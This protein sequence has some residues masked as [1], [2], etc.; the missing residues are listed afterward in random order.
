MQDLRS[1]ENEYSNDYDDSDDFHESVARTIYS[2]IVHQEEA[3]AIDLIDQLDEVD[4]LVSE[5]K[6]LLHC[7]AEEGCKNVVLALLKAG[8]DQLIPSEGDEILAD[9]LPL[10]YAA[11]NGQTKCVKALLNAL[12]GHSAAEAM[13][14]KDYAEFTPLQEAI[15]AFAEHHYYFKPLTKETEQPLQK[16]LRRKG[17]QN[18]GDLQNYLDIIDL[19]IESINIEEYAWDITPDEHSESLPY[20]CNLAHLAARFD[21]LNLFEYLFDTCPTIFYKREKLIKMGRREEDEVPDPASTPIGPTAIHTLL[22]AEY[23]KYNFCQQ[24]LLK[25][26]HEV[27]INCVDHRNRSVL[28]YLAISNNIK[29]MERVLEQAPDLLIQDVNGLTALDYAISFESVEALAVMLQSTKDKFISNFYC[30]MG[31]LLHIAYSCCQRSQNSIKSLRIMKQL[32]HFS[33]VQI[34]A[35]DRYGRTVFM[36]ATKDRNFAVLKLIQQHLHHD[37]NILV[38]GTGDAKQMLDLE[39]SGR[40]MLDMLEYTG[41]FVLDAENAA[42]IETVAE[43]AFDNQREEGIIYADDEDEGDAPIHQA[44]KQHKEGR[45]RLLSTILEDERVDDRLKNASGTKAL[46]LAKEEDESAYKL[47]RDAQYEHYKSSSTGGSGSEDDAGQSTY[48]PFLEQLMQ[49][50][51]VDDVDEVSLTDAEIDRDLEVI[52]KEVENERIPPA[53]IAE[54]YCVIHYRGINFLRD[55]FTPDKRRD[56]GKNPHENS[57]VHSKFSHCNADVSLDIAQRKPE[58]EGLLDKVDE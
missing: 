46:K 7:A 42:V 4:Q 36:C 43:F 54:R 28:F 49:E 40:D 51:E 6:T 58:D 14:T 47:L 13:S 21:M 11:Y 23:N 29:M 9:A 17:V 44:I 52:N 20:G 34:N 48:K 12:D 57:G 56:Y 22:C 1:D 24:L 33:S 26:L 45:K 32:I 5:G 50:Q 30:N 35:T 38:S 18:D 15:A 55:I 37:P 27:D 41:D 31:R 53:E 3:E 10:H 25:R 19:F 8:A 2:H 16:W 39:A